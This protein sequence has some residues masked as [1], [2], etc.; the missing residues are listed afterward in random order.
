MSSS[1]FQK[2]RFLFLSLLF[3]SYLFGAQTPHFTP[4]EQKWIDTH[5]VKVGV[6][7]DWAP[8]DFVN[9]DG[10]YSGI[11]NDY[12]TL[13]SEKSGLRF[14]KIVDKWSNNLKK[15]KEKKIDLLDAV[16]YSD[17]R[18]KYMSF[19]KP[20]MEILDYFYIR[21]DLNVSTMKDLDGKR[22]AIPKGYAHA[23]AIRKEF[24]KIKIVTVNTF[25]ES[26]DA[27]LEHRADILFD[28]QI[29]LSY[30]LEQDGIRN[31][32]PFKSY[33][34]HGLM[35]LYMSTY[36]GN[37]IL[38]SII[39]KSLDAISKD[40]R[41]E[42]YNRWVHLSKTK[43]NINAILNKN[44]ISWVKKH[45]KVRYSEVNWKP[46][47][48]IENNQMSG[49]IR[50]YLNII[51]QRTGLIFE[52]KKA[53]SWPNVLEQFK[54]NKIDM[55]PG[56]GSSPKEMQLG[57]TSKTFAT[58]P[59]VLVTKNSHSF[60]NNIKEMNGK[61]VAVPKYWTSYNYLK[62]QHPKIKIV[63][64]K[65][66]FEA[67]NL[68]KEGKADAFLGHMA[69]AMYYVGTY[70]PNS[71]YI[72]GRINYAFN[73]KMLLH[74][75]N[76][77]LLH[78][79]N[80]AL[81]SITEEEHLEINNK[82]L[83]VKV[84]QIQD[85][86][87]VLEVTFIFLLMIAG[88][89]YWNRKLS[90]EIKERKRIEQALLLEKENF[91]TL[92]EKVSDANLIIKDGKFIMANNAALKMFG[93][94]K[95]QELIS[96]SPDEWSPQFQP[97]GSSS[98]LKAAQYIKECL[99]KG[100]VRFEWVHRTTQGKDFWAD[101][102]LTKIHY[103]GSQ[104]IYV[105]IRDISEQ[106]EL[107]ENL[108]KAKEMA[109]AANKSKSEF[110]ANMSHEIRTPMNAIIGF[111][112]LLNEQLR[113]PR[114]KAYV[115]TIQNASNTLLTLINDILDLSKIE[116]GKLKIQTKPTNLFNLTDEISSIFMM[117]V[118]N[119][120]LDFIVNIDKNIPQSL[121]LD[122]VRLRQIL[123]NLIGNAVKFTQN[124]YIKLT[125]KAFNVKEHL[126]KLD[127][128]ITVEDSGIG[129][130]EDQLQKI[131]QEFEQQDGQ[132]NRK[133]GG[134]GLGL[135][136]SKRL[137]K[138]MGGDISVSSHN[139]ATFT[140]HLYNV[141]ISTIESHDNTSENDTNAAQMVFEKAKILIVDDIEDNRELIIKN[142][143]NTN[144]EIVSAV[145]GLEAIS[146]FKSEKPDLILMDIRMPNMDGYEAAA[147]IKKLSNVP[148]VALTAS[149]MQG[150]HERLKSEHFD[151]YLRKPVLRNELLLT[152]GKFLKYTVKKQKNKAPKEEI[153]LSE[154]A[155]LNLGTVLTLLQE[156]V[157]PLHSKALQSK[158]ISDIKTV[159]KRLEEIAMEYDVAAIKKYCD[160][161]NEAIDVFD[162]AKIDQLLRGFPKLL[163][164]LQNL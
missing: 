130:K 142:F 140:V 105:V 119:K 76:E 10:E 14:T 164:E 32:I 78:I 146:K 55:I 128:E 1:L 2:Y 150:E 26:V 160:A 100:T 69:V 35:K 94:A 25:S 51:S 80:K 17:K 52:F 48:I 148:I 74:K 27:V 15:I 162:I 30:K 158:S 125:I 85:Y 20:Y 151:A 68:V 72:A 37:D 143:E 4:Q 134:T 22:V 97:D 88:T 111:T 103:R 106:K 90:H 118:K 124:G 23:D 6:G 133:F 129:I 16:Y 39:N 44:E 42:I 135:S 13:I 99:K 116:A 34:A 115:K 71:L 155:K 138:M 81:A 83:K 63:P 156:K 141:D 152:L 110:L 24:P 11:A 57:I 46:I 84:N 139:G 54:E 77:T 136:I 126:S 161:L 96:S 56:I 98:K 53:K 104:A 93:L 87:F 109:D 102:G 86:T 18:N 58:F 70:Y 117:S 33:R 112:E 47:A 67:L 159:N 123:F 163:E 108:L 61:R 60:I 101:V 41:R 59:F 131:F 79:I 149:V 107:Q 62:A 145:D 5:I 64:T 66:I 153:S 7:P 114:L 95:M 91:Q 144:I 50:D 73:H 49:V 120:G 43:N 40:E 154:K 9:N 19:T 21:D 12:L 8:F 122:E 29:A 75:G 3:A 31:I 137:C 38:V 157:L 113:E 82:W 147:H 127:L 65:D 36:K 45:P 89:L 92:F 28:T 132:D 121:L